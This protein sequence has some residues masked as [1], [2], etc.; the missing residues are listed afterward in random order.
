MCET[1]TSGQTHPSCE[2]NT[3]ERRNRCA[4]PLN[5]FLQPHYHLRLEHHCLSRFSMA[6]ID[7]EPVRASRKIQRNSNVLDNSSQGDPQ[8]ACRGGGRLRIK[9]GLNNLRW[10]SCGRNT[11]GRTETRPS[12]PGSLPASQ[13]SNLEVCQGVNDGW[14]VL[15]RNPK[16][17]QTADHPLPSG[18][19]AY[20]QTGQVPTDL[21]A[22][23]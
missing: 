17:H 23:E 4:E 16:L 1:E 10:C 9:E 7:F 21:C 8:G 3:Q 14:L 12:P 6:T 20:P 19:A 11:L 13:D 18:G 5:C 15:D 2:R 22:A